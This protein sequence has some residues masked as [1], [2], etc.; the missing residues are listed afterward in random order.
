MG[1]VGGEKCN[2]CGREFTTLNSRRHHEISCCHHVG[3]LSN[4]NLGEPSSII[5][6]EISSV[7]YIV[8]EVSK[9]E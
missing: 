1:E 7:T 8:V 6:V 9:Y 3:I 4:R 2:L 5:I